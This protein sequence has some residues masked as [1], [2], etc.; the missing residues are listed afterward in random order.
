MVL[1]MIE[2]RKLR[3]VRTDR[4]IWPSRYQRNQTNFRKEDGTST[5]AIK[6]NLLETQVFVA[7]CYHKIVA[8]TRL[9]DNT[10]RSRS[11]LPPQVLDASQ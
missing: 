4:R 7:L 10:V 8:T 11:P 5:R 9:F 1:S 3:E 2:V 6:D